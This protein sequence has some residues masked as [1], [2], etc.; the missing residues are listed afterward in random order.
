MKHCRTLES[1]P[2]GWHWRIFNK[3]KSC[4]LISP[5]SSHLE[6]V[7]V[8]I[9]HRQHWFTH[10]RE[11]KPSSFPTGS[12]QDI[13]FGKWRSTTS[14]HTAA[15][16]VGIQQWWRDGAELFP[17]ARPIPQSSHP[18]PSHKPAWQGLWSSSSVWSSCNSCQVTFVNAVWQSQ[19]AR[20]AV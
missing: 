17:S 13:S 3:G 2:L 15:L 14:N 7:A 18:S 1:G 16:P 6:P 10:I 5:G 11:K 20:D 4:R 9:H 8:R 19:R 12:H